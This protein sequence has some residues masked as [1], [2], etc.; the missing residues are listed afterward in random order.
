[1]K[2]QRS[3]EYYDYFESDEWKIKKNKLKSQR[4]N[5][6]EHCG[7]EIKNLEGHHTTYDNFGDEDDEDIILLCKDCH[8]YMHQDLEFF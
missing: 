6:C 2:P 1:M 7:I 8:N 3:E 4:G 5:V